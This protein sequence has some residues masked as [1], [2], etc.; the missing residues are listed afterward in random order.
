MLRRV[1]ELVRRTEAPCSGRLSEIMNNRYSERQ[2]LALNDV[3]MGL[4]VEQV[5]WR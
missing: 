3:E 2:I 5:V 4:S 1:D